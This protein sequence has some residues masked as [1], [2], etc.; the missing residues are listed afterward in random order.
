[1]I[2]WFTIAEA[3]PTSGAVGFAFTFNTAALAVVLCPQSNPNSSAASASIIDKT[4]FTFGQAGTT[5]NI[6]YTVIAIGF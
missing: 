3:G 6:G 1:M 2:E 4:Q 5:G